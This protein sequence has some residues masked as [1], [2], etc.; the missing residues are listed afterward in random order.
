MPTSPDPLRSHLARSL[1]W[2]EAHVNLDEAIE[3]IPVD[4]RGS[5]APGFEHSIWQLLEHMRLAQKDIL[6]FCTNGQYVH[7]LKWPDDYWPRTP[8]PQDER[9][10]VVSIEDFKADRERLKQLAEDDRLDLS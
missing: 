1:D 7:S 10:W 4:R 6:D 5:L 2:K 9:A 3:G 8:A